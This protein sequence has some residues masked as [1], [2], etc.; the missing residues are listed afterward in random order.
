MNIFPTRSKFCLLKMLGWDANSDSR[1]AL[2]RW[3]FRA[4]SQP[5]WFDRLVSE[6]VG[7][8]FPYLYFGI[9]ITSRV[10]ESPK[11][12]MERK[13]TRMRQFSHFQSC[14]L[15][16]SSKM[17]GYRVG[18]GALLIELGEM[19]SNSEVCRILFILMDP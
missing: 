1:V 17:V 18:G 7:T 15:C 8:C 9:K 3:E 6:L 11:I 12:R 4:A 19:A 14:V 10:C 5:R 13:C 16:Y 2:F